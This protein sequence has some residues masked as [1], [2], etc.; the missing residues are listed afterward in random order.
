MHNRKAVVI[1]L[2]LSAAFATV[3]GGCSADIT[4]IFAPLVDENYYPETVKLADIDISVK[5]NDEIG[6][7]F[8]TKSGEAVTANNAVS[9]GVFDT[10]SPTVIYF[11]GERQSFYGYDVWQSKGFNTGIIFWKPFYG[12][13]AEGKIW[14]TTDASWDT[15]GAKGI[16]K[17]CS[18]CELISAYYLDFTSDITYNGGEIRFIG[19]EKGATLAVSV[20]AYLTEKE[21][22]ENVSAD[23]IPARLTLFETEFGTDFCDTEKVVEAL[24]VTYKRGVTAEALNTVCGD[25]YQKVSFGTNSL[26]NYRYDGDETLAKDCAYTEYWYV[27]ALKSDALITDNAMNNSGEFVPTASL[28]ESYVA[29]RKNIV[30]AMEENTT[31]D[32]ADDVIKSVNV[33]FAGVSGIAFFDSGTDGVFR[34]GIGARAKGVKIELYLISGTE[35]RLMGSYMTDSDGVYLITVPKIYAN[36]FD[37]FYVVAYPPTDA[38]ITAFSEVPYGNGI[39]A[40][41]NLSEYFSFTHMKSLKIINVGVTPN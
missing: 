16:I 29:A 15:D 28:S 24:D 37:D 34:S 10:D 38:E 12:E 30:Y 31:L 41:T 1:I 2:I 6:L 9:A 35:H 7:F 8:L 26:I 33:T 14:G 20:A 5:L 19:A 39:H 4:E 22:A 21:R 36:G 23:V 25:N 32:Y 3:L 11:C 18:V 13:G 27:S 40:E 17:S